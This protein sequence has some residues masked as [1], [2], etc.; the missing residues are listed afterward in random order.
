MSAKYMQQPMIEKGLYPLGCALFRE[1]PYPSD[2]QL[3]GV[4][5]K[6]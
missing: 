5:F 4:V 1:T 3:M 6:V 2:Q